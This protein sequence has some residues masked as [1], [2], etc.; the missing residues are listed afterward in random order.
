MS[1]SHSDL[2]LIKPLPLQTESPLVPRVPLLRQALSRGRTSASL[3]ATVITPSLTQRGLLACIASLP[4]LGER[5]RAI[6]DSRQGSASGFPAFSVLWSL[7]LC[8]EV[9]W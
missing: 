3:D 9:V 2:L 1:S 4:P 8:K 6:S 5:G 7:V